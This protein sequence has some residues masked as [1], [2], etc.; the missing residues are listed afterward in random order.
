MDSNARHQHTEGHLQ[1]ALKEAG[2]WNCENGCRRLILLNPHLG[3]AAWQQH[4][5]HWPEGLH[6]L[7]MWEFDFCEV[8]QTCSNTGWCMP[9]ILLAPS[10]PSRI[11]IV[12]TQLI[13]KTSYFWCA[14]KNPEHTSLAIA[15]FSLQLQGLPGWLGH[16]H[17]YP[18]PQRIA[19]LQ[20]QQK[21]A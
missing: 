19:F 18:T 15:S 11:E 14:V 2:A 6:L 3:T 9:A 12:S 17:L 8:S 16:H 5:L 13:L 10:A 21:R 7:K 1:G 4:Y 20:K